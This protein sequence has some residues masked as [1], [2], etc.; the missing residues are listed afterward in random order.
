MLVQN[1]KFLLEFKFA[2]SSDTTWWYDTGEEILHTLVG[3]NKCVS[4]DGVVVYNLIF[5]R[6]GIFFALMNQ[7]EKK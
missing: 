4:K 6:L 5:W 7:G 3:L 2:N 1:K